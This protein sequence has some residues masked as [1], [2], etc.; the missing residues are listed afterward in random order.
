M[1]LK[2]RLVTTPILRRPIKGR[3][4]QLHTNWSRLG[5]GTMLT[6][7]DDEGKEFVVAYVS[8]SM[9]RSHAIVHTRESV[10]QQ[11]GL[12]H[13]S[14]VTCLAHSLPLSL[15]ISRSSG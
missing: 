14:N 15:M 5:L 1:E 9:Q 13:T 4:F 10:W 3:P 8:H 7:C 6:Q 12:L 2:A 11:C